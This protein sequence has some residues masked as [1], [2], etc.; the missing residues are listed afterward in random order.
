MF[1]PYFDLDSIIFTINHSNVCLPLKLLLIRP[2]RKSGALFCR[3][4]F[5]SLSL[6]DVSKNLHVKEHSLKTFNVFAFHFTSC[7]LKLL[8]CQS[9]YSGARKFTLRN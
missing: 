4:C 3:F 6:T 5:S 2:R 1:N 8:V 7:I 9:K